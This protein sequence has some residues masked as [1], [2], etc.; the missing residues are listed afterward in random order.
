MCRRGGATAES[1]LHMSTSLPNPVQSQR[2]DC[3]E[4]IWDKIGEVMP[5]IADPPIGLGRTLR[6]TLLA[7]CDVGWGGLLPKCR[8]EGCNEHF[9]RDGR[10]L[11]QST[12]NTLAY[13]WHFCFQMQF[14]QE[15]HH[16]LHMMNYHIRGKWKKVRI[17]TYCLQIV[18]DV[19][20]HACCTSDWQQGLILHK[21]QILWVM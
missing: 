1:Q 2:R 12:K 5:H 21:M 18:F 7:M 15:C 3:Q 13:F 17:N 4:K 9:S 19:F 14:K 16:D 20:P 11:R 10:C 6:K 8:T